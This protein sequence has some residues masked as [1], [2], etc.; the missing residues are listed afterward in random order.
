MVRRVAISTDLGGRL[1]SPPGEAS[2]RRGRPPHRIRTC[3]SFCGAAARKAVPLIV[4]H[5]R[6]RSSPW[7]LLRILRSAC[8]GRDGTVYGL[9]NLA[10]VDRSPQV[11]TGQQ[12]VQ[13]SPSNVICRTSRSVSY[14]AWWRPSR[15]RGS[16]D[17]RQVLPCRR[18]RARGWV[19]SWGVNPEPLSDW[20][21]RAGI[22]SSEKGGLAPLLRCARHGALGRRFGPRG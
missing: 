17:A 5:A 2:N 15:H 19:S 11:P 18:G 3:A 6:R 9:V 10:A 14:Q 8:Q 1:G 7:V 22:D 16:I 20:V 13:L 4:D 21:I 12:R